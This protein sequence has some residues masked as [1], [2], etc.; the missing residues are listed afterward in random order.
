VE[1][2]SAWGKK[3]VDRRERDIVREERDSVCEREIEREREER[4]V[5][6]KEM[7]QRESSVLSKRH[8]VTPGITYQNSFLFVES[9]SIRDL[10]KR[11]HGLRSGFRVSCMSFSWH[12]FL[13]LAV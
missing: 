10:C 3:N 11:L 5:S 8:K 6:I 12:S 2:E 7:F 1:R 4:D 9:M 13:P